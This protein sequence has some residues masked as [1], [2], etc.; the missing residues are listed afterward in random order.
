MT[1]SDL[2]SG[3][4]SEVGSPAMGN[5]T[6]D[7]LKLLMKSQQTGGQSLAQL[8]PY[9]PYLNN[10][11]SYSANSRSLAGAIGN[12]DDPRYQKLY[13]GFKQQGQQNLSES[14]AEM[15]RQ[16][17]KSSMLG[18]TPLFSPERGGETA[19]R[20]L[21]KGYQDVQNQASNQAFGQLG[22]E[23]QAAQ[24]QDALK[25]KNALQKSDVFGNATAAIAK[26]FGL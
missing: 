21:T 22:N 11:D 16:N 1:I 17:R 19:F 8:I 12:P 24:Q 3:T 4:S 10:M 2:F 9:L 15:D 23:Y 26:L 7:L 18:R 13:G 14:I 20:G 25:Q 5:S 6:G